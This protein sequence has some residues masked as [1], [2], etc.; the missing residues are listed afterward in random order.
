MNK[1]KVMLMHKKPTM[2]DLAQPNLSKRTRVAVLAA[3]DEA[4][5]EQQKVLKK[6]KT[7]A[8]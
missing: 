3:F 1:T 6:A 4:R 2:Q 5:R 7:L 8:K